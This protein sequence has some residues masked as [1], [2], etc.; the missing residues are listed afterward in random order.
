M[1]L[2]N[3]SKTEKEMGV[4]DLPLPWKSKPVLTEERLLLHTDDDIS[5]PHADTGK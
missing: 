4:M 2:T 5:H 1:R 3:S